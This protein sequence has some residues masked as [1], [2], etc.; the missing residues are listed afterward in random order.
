MTEED[1]TL[2]DGIRPAFP[3]QETGAIVP[4]GASGTVRQDSLALDAPGVPPI[5]VEEAAG[6]DRAIILPAG[7]TASP[8]VRTNVVAPERIPT[9]PV[10]DPGDTTI[11]DP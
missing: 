2:G 6:L 11:V 1:K 4:S 5:I 8:T 3:L 10:V 7:V 9:D